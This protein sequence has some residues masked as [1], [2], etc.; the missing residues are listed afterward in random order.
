M[1]SDYLSPSAMA[2]EGMVGA[3][4]LNFRFVW[5]S[6]SHEHLLPGSAISNYLEVIEQ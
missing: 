6:A 2:D 3:Q 1:E 5:F 4:S